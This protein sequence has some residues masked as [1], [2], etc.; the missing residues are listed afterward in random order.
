MG[1]Q[2]LAQHRGDIGIS[3][4]PAGSGDKISVVAGVNP[5]PIPTQPLPAGSQGSVERKIKSCSALV[6]CVT[7]GKCMLLSGLRVPIWTRKSLG[8]NNGGF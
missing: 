4:S 3:A 8:S 5:T 2:T 6:C 1:S 7:L